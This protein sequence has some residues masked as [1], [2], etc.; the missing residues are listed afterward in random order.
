MRGRSARAGRSERASAGAGASGASAL[1]PAYRDCVLAPGSSSS[2]PPAG[3][4]H[5]ALPSGVRQSGRE[6]SRCMARSILERP[7]QAP[8]RT[9]PGRTGMPAAR[10]KGESMLAG[11]ALRDRRHARFR[12]AISP[13]SRPRIV[14]TRRRY[15][16]G[17]PSRRTGSYGSS[18]STRRTRP[19]P[20]TSPVCAAGRVGFTWPCHQSVRTR[21]RRL[22]SGS[23]LDAFAASMKK[24]HVVAGLVFIARID[25]A[26][27]PRPFR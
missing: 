22:A 23:K 2:I 9:W 26:G 16:V 5:S 15:I 3:C 27:S 8:P 20:A 24:T 13:A 18:P 1:A 11:P 7:S 25:A 14:L 10:W 6:R 19:E 12:T 17:G 4:A 21:N